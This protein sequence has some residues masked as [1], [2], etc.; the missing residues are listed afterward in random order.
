MKSSLFLL[1]CVFSV[2]LF[3]CNSGW[4]NTTIH[5]TSDMSDVG[6]TTNENSN[7]QLW[8]GSWDD[9]TKKLIDD[10]FKNKVFVEYI[11]NNSWDSKVL[12]VAQAWG[13]RLEDETWW[14]KFILDHNTFLY[15]RASWDYK[16][17]YSSWHVVECSSDS[18][19]YKETELSNGDISITCDGDT[20]EY[21]EKMANEEFYPTTIIDVVIEDENMTKTLQWSDGKRLENLKV[22]L[23]IMWLYEKI[24]TAKI[25]I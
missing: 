23:P 22:S 6:D 12:T 1:L 4:V 20:W 17:V 2:T 10:I 14:Y 16:T 25:L 9:S 8:E 19:F 18:E 11:N 24:T 7:Y 13:V 21:H 5:D 15:V 3:G